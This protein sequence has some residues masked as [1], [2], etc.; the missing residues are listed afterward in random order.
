[1]RKF[2]LGYN[3]IVFAFVF[4][5]VLLSLNRPNPELIALLVISLIGVVAII[6]LFLKKN[7]YASLL[8]LVLLFLFQSISGTISG[9]YYKFIIGPTLFFAYFKNPDAITKFGAT[10]NFS[11]NVSA[12]KQD[13][14]IFVINILH[15]LMFIYFIRWLNK[16]EKIKA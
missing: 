8:S 12:R 7:M 14:P 16:V 15:L 3:F 11:C 10:I 6:S 2:V 1:M 5:I 9:I 4:V 13:D